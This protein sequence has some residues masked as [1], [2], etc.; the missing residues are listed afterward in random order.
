MNCQQLSLI[1]KI[2]YKC[3]LNNIVQR[4]PLNGVNFG[5]ERVDSVEHGLNAI[6]N[7]AQ[8]HRNLNYVIFFY[9]NV[10]IFII[11]RFVVQ[12]SVRI[13]DH[14]ALFLAIFFVVVVFFLVRIVVVVFFL[15]IIVIVAA[16]FGL[17]VGSNT[18]PI[19]VL[20]LVV[21]V[22]FIARIVVQFVWVILIVRVS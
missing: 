10:V 16:I 14:D 15:V 12:I 11:R 4:K 1:F 5:L 22:F 20:V 7:T 17:C 19:G 2:I 21:V 13:V 9:F 8:S 3:K 18:G 6:L